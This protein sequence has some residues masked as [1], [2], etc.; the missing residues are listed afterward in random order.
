YYNDSFSTTPETAIAAIQAFD[1]PKVLILGG[2][3][4]HSDFREL[5]RVI[6]ESSSIRAII[7]IGEEW[8][9]IRSEVR[10]PISDIRII[11]GCTTMKD[12][13]E[14]AKNVAKPGDVVLLSPACASFGMFQNYKDR[15]DQF[16]NEVAKLSKTPL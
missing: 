1:A 14:V 5:G 9:R 8:Q 2:S 6:S 15:G 7:G 3:T 10:H 12:I 16:R 13:V 11:E 4:K